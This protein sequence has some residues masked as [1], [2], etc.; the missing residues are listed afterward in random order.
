MLITCLH[1]TQRNIAIFEAAKPEGVSLIHHVRS[2]LLRR[3]L[4][5]PDQTVVEE[6]RQHL[7]RLQQGSDAVLLTCAFLSD[8]AQDSS[9]SA[10]KILFEA[11]NGCADGNKV[12]LLFANPAMAETV[13]AQFDQLTTKC[14]LSLVH[15]ADA[16]NA[17]VLGDFASFIDLIKQ[18]IAQSN[19]D[20]IVLFQPSMTEAAG[21]DPRVLRSPHVSLQAIKDKKLRA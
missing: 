17:Y 20:V 1:T 13:H 14:D 2:D 12:D 21:D 16:W 10:D 5:C 7:K 8:A 18:R 19:A 3:A 11:V 4:T 15:V 9:Y 6:T